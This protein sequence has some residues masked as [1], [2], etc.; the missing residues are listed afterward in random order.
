MV[1]Y[2]Q[3]ATMRAKSDRQGAGILEVSDRRCE[4]VAVRLGHIAILRLGSGPP[5]VLLHGIPLSLLT[6]RHNTNPL[7]CNFTVVAL[8]L[9]GFGLSD[10]P[11]ET[12]YSV[13]AQAR[14]V[15]EVLDRLGLIRVHVVGSS[16]GCAVAITLAHQDPDRVGKLVLINPVC[17]PQGRHS[18]TR[19]ARIGLISTLAPAALRAPSLGR[20]LMQRSLRRSYADPELA[21]PELV[22]ASHALLTRQSGERTYL[23]ALRQLDESD[24]ARRVPGLSHETLVIWGGR[25]RVLPAADGYRLRSELRSSRLEVMSEAGHFP[26]EEVPDRVNPLI[27]AFLAGRDP[28]VDRG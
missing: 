3:M 22:A 1:D 28:T 8:D 7:A 16:Y 15:R 27:A 21:T 20:Q 25:D 12:D 9:L 10:K 5:I 18:A 23:A 2:I 24:V 17:Y 26:H 6:W 13:P 14:V 11:L 19:L 4:R